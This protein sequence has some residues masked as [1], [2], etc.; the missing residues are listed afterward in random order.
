SPDHARLLVSA[1]QPGSNENGFWSLPLKGGSPE[2]LGLIT[3]RDD[4]WSADGL[5]L[6]FG[7]GPKLFVAD[8]DGEHP[9]E[10][11]TASGEVFAARFSPDGRSIRFTVG[12]VGANK[13]SLWEI[14]ADG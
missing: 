11:F 8:A 2:R 6:A 12:D 7:K 1:A 9:T 14:E 3:G 5:R 13:T 4:S 10:L